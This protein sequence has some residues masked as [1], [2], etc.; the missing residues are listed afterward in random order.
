MVRLQAMPSDLAAVADM[1]PLRRILC[2][3]AQVAGLSLALTACTVGSNAPPSVSES[4]I[5]QQMTHD[6]RH[7]AAMAVQIAME[8]RDD[9]ESSTWT[10]GMSGNHGAVVPRR[11]YRSRGGAY[12]R[13]YDEMVTVAGVTATYSR[14]ACRDGSGRWT[15]VT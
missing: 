2:G 5:R 13:R 10:N 9:N 12:C 15:T 11:S 14:T 7:I 8:R 3:L 6:D 1:R 4:D